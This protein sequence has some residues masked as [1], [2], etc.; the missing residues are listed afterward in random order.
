R[1]EA[2]GGVLS[3]SGNGGR[4]GKEAGKRMINRPSTYLDHA[5]AS[6]NLEAQGRFRRETE[7][8]ITGTPTYPRQPSSSPWSTPDPSGPEP[9]L[10]YEIDALPELG[11]LGGAPASALAETATP[12]GSDST[13]VV[14]PQL[15]RRRV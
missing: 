7:S 5:I 4:N 11:G 8:K 2:S 13:G 1:T 9:P 6:A 15:F 14:T 3:C 12:K 10:G